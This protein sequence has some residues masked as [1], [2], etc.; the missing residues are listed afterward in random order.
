MTCNSADLSSLLFVKLV[1]SAAFAFL[2]NSVVRS[3][4]FTFLSNASFTLPA[5]TSL[6]A[7]PLAVISLAKLGVTLTLPSAP[8]VTEIAS[9]LLLVIEF[10]SLLDAIVTALP[11]AVKVIFLPATNFT[12]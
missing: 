6:F 8:V 3:S 1:T 12:L 10:T 9:P 2:F 7:S 4:L 11:F 5:V